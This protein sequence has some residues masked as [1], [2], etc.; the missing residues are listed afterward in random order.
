MEQRQAEREKTP[1]KTNTKT[2]NSTHLRS[3]YKGHQENITYESKIPDVICSK[4][5][6]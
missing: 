4:K 1:I 6:K 2:K 3:G 5:I